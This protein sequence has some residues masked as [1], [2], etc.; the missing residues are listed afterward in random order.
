MFI[1]L[2]EVIDCI[3]GVVGA[4]TRAVAKLNVRPHRFMMFAAYLRFLTTSRLEN[5]QVLRNLAFW[6]INNG[7]RFARC[8]WPPNVS[9]TCNCDGVV[10]QQSQLAN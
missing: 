7:L 5:L 4:Y 2:P 10:S 1:L 3:Y 6:S 9:Q 8:V